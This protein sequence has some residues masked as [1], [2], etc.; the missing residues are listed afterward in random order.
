MLEQL[1]AFY[2]IWRPFLLGLAALACA[3]LAAWERPC[4]PLR[5]LLGVSGTAVFLWA[6]LP[7][8]PL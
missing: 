8:L 3:A 2:V 4:R 7:Y 6:A 1:A 5:I